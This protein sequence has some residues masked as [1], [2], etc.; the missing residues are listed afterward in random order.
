[1]NGY[2]Y[3]IFNCDVGLKPENHVTLNASIWKNGI[4]YAGPDLVS[5]REFRRIYQVDR[6]MRP[7]FSTYERIYENE[8]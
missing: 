8:Q 7:E 3:R 1:M 4:C 6:K 5:G 2:S